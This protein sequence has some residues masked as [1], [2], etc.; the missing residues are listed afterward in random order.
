M[1]ALITNPVK[2]L[3]TSISAGATLGGS[4]AGPIG[5]AIGSGVGAVVGGSILIT[6]VVLQSR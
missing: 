6:A 1:K 4:V 5:A 3:G 2:V